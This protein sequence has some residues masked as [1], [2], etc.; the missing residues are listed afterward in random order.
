VSYRGVEIKHVQIMKVCVDYGGVNLKERRII[1]NSNDYLDIDV[2][3]GAPDG[4]ETIWN[5]RHKFSITR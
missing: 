4:N 3:G 1:T 2:H 5:C